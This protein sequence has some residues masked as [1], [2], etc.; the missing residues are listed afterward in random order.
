VSKLPPLVVLLLQLGACPEAV[1]WAGNKPI[2]ASTLKAC[3]RPDWRNWLAGA[4]KIG[5][6][7]PAP[8]WISA[9]KTALSGYGSGCG[10]GYGYGYGSGYGSGDGYGSGYGYG[11]G[12]GDGDATPLKASRS[13]KS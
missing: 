11:S 2:S 9:A 8:R 6:N 5:T 1:A 10:S 4:L 12:S 13:E 7:E 3:K